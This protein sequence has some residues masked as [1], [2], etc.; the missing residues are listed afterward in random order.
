MRAQH[1]H[2]VTYWHFAA[3]ITALITIL[4]SCFIHG[5]RKLT[6][7]LIKN[8]WANSLL[9]RNKISVQRTASSHQFEH[10]VRPYGTYPLHTTHANL[11]W[12]LTYSPFAYCG[13]CT[14]TPGTVSPPPHRIARGSMGGIYLQSFTVLISRLLKVSMSARAHA[15]K[16]CARARADL[17]Y[18]ALIENF[19]EFKFSLFFNRPGFSLDSLLYNSITTRLFSLRHSFGEFNLFLCMF[20]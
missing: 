19:R 2:A 11:C 7:I 20:N 18:I 12:L 13:V 16:F 15:H 1:P 10:T 8:F 5:T 4:H 6:S 9:A 3:R 17:L 14:L